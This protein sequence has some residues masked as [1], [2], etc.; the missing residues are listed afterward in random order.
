MTHRLNSPGLESL[1]ASLHKSATK[2]RHRYCVVLSGENHWATRAAREL[3]SIYSSENALHVT[4]AGT[5]LWDDRNL[6]SVTPEKARQYLGSELGVV[7]YDCYAGFDP[8][9]V[10]ILGGTILAGGLLVAIIPE[11]SNWPEYQ[12]FQDPQYSRIIAYGDDPPKISAYLLRLSRI[13]SNSPH[14][15]YLSQHGDLPE[16]DPENSA[17]G[18]MPPDLSDQLQA[19]K[20]VKKVITGQRKRPVVLLSDRGRGKSAALGIAAKEILEDQ[21][22]RI[23]VTGINLG[24]VANLFKHAEI[25]PADSAV[26]LCFYPVDKLVREKIDIDLLLVDEAASI[27]IPQL[28]K[29]LDKFP[30]IAFASTVHGYEGTGRGFALKFK[31][32]LDKKTRGWRSCILDS[33]IRWAEYDPLEQFLYDLLLLNADPDPVMQAGFNIDQLNF[34]IP[35]QTALAND[36]QLL[37][38]VFGLLTQAHYRTRPYD[39]RHLLEAQNTTVFTVSHHSTILAVAFVALEGG[40]D[41]AMA[42]KIWA[43]QARPQG[44]LLPEQLGA[45]QGLVDAPRLKFARIL[46]IAVL[47]ELQSLGIGSTLLDYIEKH[48]QDKAD[49][50]GA[51]FGINMPV[52]NFWFKNGFFPVR[53]GVGKSQNTGSQPGTL[54]KGMSTSGINLESR[55]LDKF[56]KVFHH[57]L[58]TSL[59]DLEPELVKLIYRGMN[60]NDLQADFSTVDLT[61]LSG[62]GFAHQ[63]IDNMTGLLTRMAEFILMATGDENRESARQLLLVERIL[64]RNP[65][66]RCHSLGDNRGKSQGVSA[67]RQLVRKFLIDHYRLEIEPILK[68]YNLQY[69]LQGDLKSDN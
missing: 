25:N 67:I 68:T 24:A 40:F 15:I 9:A 52:L 60:K 31:Q 1:G 54:I 29:L 58:S 50:I 41:D 26:G 43:N 61:E 36:E 38:N 17:P 66:K 42:K 39:L 18:A 69:D 19:I 44:H 46:R 30:R 37:K 45:Q 56:S 33:P 53:I 34:G 59:S 32:I 11:I 55:A 28:E 3:C 23:G 13:I 51:S 63:G 48:Y 10:G 5:P 2:N 27:P 20:S 8:D 16:F 64:Q 6:E 47:P 21:S 35:D 4:D 65:W 49:C 12:N 22:I 57:L 14:C 7:V 62:F